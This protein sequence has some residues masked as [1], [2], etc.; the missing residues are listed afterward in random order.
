MREIELKFVIDDQ[1]TRQLRAC[2]KALSLG[3]GS[4]KIRTLSSIYLDTTEGTLKKAG[5]TLRLRR[6]G[7]RWAQT[8]ETKAVLHCGLSQV[9][10]VENPAPGGRLCL[11]AIPDV[12]IREEIIRRVI[13]APLRPVFETMIRRSANELSLEDGTRA[14]LAIDIGEIHAGEHS[15]ELRE[16]KIERIEG[17]LGGLFDIAHLLFLKGA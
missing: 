7:R 2:L 1:G 9:T 3:N 8:V 17:S 10:E 12:A 16:L 15:A 13:G 4:L 6:D 11:E 5:I 14:E